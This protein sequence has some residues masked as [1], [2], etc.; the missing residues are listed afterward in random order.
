MRRLKQTTAA[1]AALLLV[2]GGLARAGEFTW[3]FDTDPTTGT[4]PLIIAG[5]NPSIWND[6]GGNPGGFLAITYPVEGQNGFILFP[7]IDN[8]ALITAFEL[9]ADVRSGNS[10]GERAADGWSVSLARS[11]DPI[12]A[13]LPGSI[14]SGYAGDVPEAGSTTGIAISFDTW[15]GNALPDGPDIEGLI[16]RV[17][18]RTVARVELPT[19]HG[20]CDDATSLQT[21]PRDAD[22]W[23]AGGDPY[24]P[25][26]W[27]QL[28]W[29]PLRVVVDDLSRVSVYWKER[30]ILEN[31][32]SD[33]FPSPGRILL[34]GRTGGANSNVHFD[35]VTLRTT[36]TGADDEPPT[37]P[38]FLNAV[39][40]GSAR[41]LLEWGESTDDSGRVGYELERDGAQIPG[42]FTATTYE[43]RSV[44][45]GSTHT[46]RVRATDVAGN[47]SAWVPATPVSV[48]TPQDVEA[49]ASLRA[50]IFDGIAGAIQ[51][52][53]AILDPIYTSGEFTRV[54]Y[55]SGLS[56]GE[57]TNFGDTYG[58]NYLLRI[59]G[60]ITPAVSGS[61]RFFVRSDDASEF[62]LNPDG[63]GIPDPNM[64]FPDATETT[65]C[66][67]FLEPDDAA[68]D[69]PTS[70]PIALTAGTSYGFIFLVKEG[71]GGD[72]G[73]IAWRLEGDTT[74]AAELQPIR[75]AV[76]S[77]RAD[78]VGTVLEVTQQPQSMEAVINSPASLTVGLNASTPY[79]NIAP[80]YQWRKNGT[81]IPGANSATLEFPMVTAAD[82]GTYSVQVWLSGLTVTSADAVVTTVEDTVP[83]TINSV[84]T[85]DTFTRI[86]VNFSEP[87]VAP[88]ATTAGNYTV[89]G[90][91]TVSAAVL[92][93]DRFS[94]S[95]TTSAMTADTDYTLTVN[96]VVDLAGNPI[97]AGTT[98]SF[99]TWA[100]QMG[101]A[102]YEYWL[103]IEGVAVAL[104]TS[105]PR[106]P[107]NPDGVQI[108]EGEYM[109]PINWADNFGAR[110]S[111]W[112][113]PPQTG[114]YVFFLSADDNAE[115][116]L[117]TDD[118]PA[119]KRLIAI[120]P[121]WNDPRQWAI[122]DRRPNGE[123]RS[124]LF[125]GTEW[126]AGN[127]IELTEGQRYYTEILYKEGGGGDNAGAAW[128]LVGQP[129]PAPG[130]PGI[131]AIG[132][133]APLVA[134]NPVLAVTVEN[135]NLVITFEGTLQ[136]ADAIGDWSDTT[137]SSPATVTPGATGNKFY[138]AVR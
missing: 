26:S 43:D 2:A 136:E 8:G 48:T 33:F 89:S 124:D 28:C 23:A 85:D 130:T 71:G 106:F 114:S 97:A 16:V 12:L 119:N 120:E 57:W 4:N 14:T 123:N 70:R 35:N 39:E 109:S 17:D 25:E 122:T 37:D 95:L 101:R 5:N 54:R 69:Y 41:V 31:F 118:S 107:D 115:L 86:V 46:Y 13:N 129:D 110:L 103:G 126:P 84:D 22:Y 81:A 60:T 6:S 74:P 44:L 1:I 53:A 111:G 59:T 3:T 62:H 47:K 52:P 121:E 9:T 94:V 77:G 137:L 133:Y 108:M 91:V 102:K 63:P 76:L 72:W 36:T 27:A 96:N 20:A 11:N 21:G 99:R 80:V 134:E 75:G 51:I 100:F 61:Y 10:T 125:A 128:K 7:D 58:D 117:S 15:A 113:V 116:Y 92:S 65:C 132:T 105:D 42:A 135:G 55:L 50:E 112:I 83:P 78:P 30:A 127:T 40:V 138:R 79:P 82:A 29:Q 67:A 88:S 104:L 24:D 87:V 34:A 45:P 90:G 32:E 38:G 18:N 98:F 49:V 131:A 66:R 93:D 68:A 56:F 19:R 64:Q 73:Q